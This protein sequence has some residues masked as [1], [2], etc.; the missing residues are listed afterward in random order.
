MGG[1]AV[2]KVVE[3]AVS[4]GS[5][6]DFGDSAGTGISHIFAVA[7]GFHVL[8]PDIALHAEDVLFV[9]RFDALN[10]WVE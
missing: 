1:E 3:V 7:V 9:A 2:E 4:L 5:P 6:S 10:C 8:G